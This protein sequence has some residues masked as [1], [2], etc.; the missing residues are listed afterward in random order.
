MRRPRG[1]QTE[2]EPPPA[3]RNANRARPPAPPP[4]SAGSPRGRRETRPSFV[5][6]W[7]DYKLPFRMK[8]VIEC[9]PNISE[10]NDRSRVDAIASA[11]RE[12]PGA[13]LLGV[14]SDP[15]HNRSVLTFV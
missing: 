7:E 11:V 5:S 12:T 14:S 1:G 4:R 10:G 13:R 15:S 9:V 3:A 8:N 2:D 6:R